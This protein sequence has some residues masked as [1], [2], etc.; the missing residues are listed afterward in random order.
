MEVR[1]Q[2]RKQAIVT[3]LSLMLLVGIAAA[4]PGTTATTEQ[5][6]SFIGTTP[7]AT[8]VEEL[9]AQF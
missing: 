1:N 5:P 3:I 8:T 2:S 7:D 4:A 9:P 6:Q